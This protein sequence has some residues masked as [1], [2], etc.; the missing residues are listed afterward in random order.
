MKQ[1]SKEG[2]VWLLGCQNVPSLSQISV[3]EGF[4]SSS[5]VHLEAR[6]PYSV[7]WSAE[8]EHTRVVLFSSLAICHGSLPDK[9]SSLHQILQTPQEVPVHLAIGVAVPGA[10]LT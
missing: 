7:A 5:T 9:F 3:A 2:G 10:A 6:A 8:L 1:K 4:F